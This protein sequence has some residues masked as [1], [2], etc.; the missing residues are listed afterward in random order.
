M[1]Y[2]GDSDNDLED[3]TNASKN[4]SNIS[5]M[6]YLKSKI[7]SKDKDDKN[8][9]NSGKDDDNS[10]NEHDDDESSV[11]ESESEETQPTNIAQHD[12]KPAP[13]LWTVK[14]RGLPF[15][16]KDKHISEFFSP[17]KCVDIRLV[18]N[19]KGQPSGRAF[20]DFECKED[21]EKALKRNKDYLEGRYIELFR[22]DSKM[23]GQKQSEQQEEKPWVKKLKESRN[24]EEDESIGEVS[25]HYW[26]FLHYVLV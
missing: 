25:I 3:Q 2:L 12:S 14:M 16:V 8:I 7:V 23:F 20:V 6:D 22:D 9:D 17:M 10:A 5:D 21:Q 19:K 11:D 26:Y 13:I 24:E 4:V 15:K 18:K 1:I